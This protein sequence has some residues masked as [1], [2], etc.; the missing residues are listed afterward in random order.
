M[1]E[2]ALRYLACPACGGGFALHADV[3]RDEQV[4]TGRLTCERCGRRYVIAGGVPRFAQQVDTIEKQTAEA[5]GYEWTRYS[6]LA[7]RYRQQ[8]LDW[9]RPVEPA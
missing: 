2:G 6:E 5:F 4:E 3:A 8:F 7:D 9:I 1:R